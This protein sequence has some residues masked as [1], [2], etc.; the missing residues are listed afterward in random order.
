MLP[1]LAPP[2]PVRAE[3]LFGELETVRRRGFAISDEDVTVG[4]AAI[5]APIRNHRGAVTAALSIS[6]VR[7]AIL[8]ANRARMTGLVVD[9]A[10]AVSA[11]LGFTP[12]HAGSRA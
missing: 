12:A 7:P 9:A 10:A 6:G 11:S 5:G 3:H 2:L 1:P 8:G 4:I